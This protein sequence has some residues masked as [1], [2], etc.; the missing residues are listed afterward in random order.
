MEGKTGPLCHR[1]CDAQFETVAA[2]HD[3]LSKENMA[4]VT[5]PFDYDTLP[6]PGGIVPICIE[7]TDRNGCLINHDWFRAV[8]PIAD[9]L[10]RLS[11]RTLDDVWYVSEITEASVHA[12]WGKHR[13]NLGRSPSARIYA[14]A[15]WKALDLRVGGRNARRGVEVELLDSIRAKLRSAHDVHGQVEFDELK[16][17]LARHFDAQGVPHIDKMM[18]MWLSGHEWNDIAEHIGKKPKA[19]TQDFWRWFRRGLRDLN[20]R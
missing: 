3:S 1:A 12:L 10:R 11:R 5:I 9:Q 2:N 6:D 14:H 18:H 17:L 7:D 19:A 20:L 16:G 15:K 8:V 4:I 13:H